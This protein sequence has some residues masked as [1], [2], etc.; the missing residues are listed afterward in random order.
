MIGGVSVT[1]PTPVATAP[2]STVEVMRTLVRAYAE[3]P[4]VREVAVV[5]NAP[6]EPDALRAGH[7]DACDLVIRCSSFVLDRPAGAAVV[8][9]RTHV[10]VV[11]RGLRASP[12]AFDSYRERLYLLAEP[13]R[14]H[15]EPDGRPACWPAD[16]GVVPVPNREI[17]LPLCDALE[18]P[19]RAEPSWPTTGLI[20]SWIA[21]TLFPD[22]TLHV[23][24]F[25]MIDD[26][27]QTEWQRAWGGSGA[28][29]AEH[30]IYAEGRLLR[31]WINAGE[32]RWLR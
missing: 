18:L 30:R 17:I 25:S 23:A 16:L 14:L 12:D 27:D 20:A 6:L 19:S 29:G 21:R 2:E 10:V 22:A 15:W 32:V 5:G 3:R 7:I 4:D 9:R 8:G 31:S 1:Q 13:G 24:G 11:H 28:V 26:P